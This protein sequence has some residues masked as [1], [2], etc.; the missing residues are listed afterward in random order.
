MGINFNN[1]NFG[2]LTANAARTNS[3]KAKQQNAPAQVGKNEVTQK[4]STLNEATLKAGEGT[5]FDSNRI[6]D[7]KLEDEPT[8]GKDGFQTIGEGL[9]WVVDQIASHFL[10]WL[11]LFF[12]PIINPADPNGLHGDQ[13]MA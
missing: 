9:A 6:L 13:P 10:P 7:K 1:N 12:P 5:K 8:T 4:S 3:A 2:K 11:D